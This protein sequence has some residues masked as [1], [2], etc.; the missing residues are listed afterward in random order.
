MAI[1]GGSF[2]K[3]ETRE[4]DTY[5][6]H[7]TQKEHPRV[8]FLPTAAKDDQGYAKRFKQYYRSLGYEVQALR[9]LHTKLSYDEIKEMFFSC[10]ILY[11][12]GGSLVFLMKTLQEMNLIDV[13]KEAYEKGVYCAGYSAG[14]SLFYTYGY[15]DIA[16]DGKVFDYVKGL[17]LVEG[18]FCPH[19]QDKKRIGFYKEDTFLSLPRY[20]CVDQNAYLTEDGKTRSFY[21][22]NEK[23]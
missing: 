7:K 16:S 23:Q 6:I 14:A 4:L 20:G 18:I 13:I 1:G 8:L 12:G 2:Q 10:D 19:A 9:L 22:N 5:L 3:G 17:G 21:K 15:S 11:F